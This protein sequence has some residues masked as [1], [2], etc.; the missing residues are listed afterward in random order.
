MW[1]CPDGYPGTPHGQLTLRVDAAPL[2]RCLQPGGQ[3]AVEKVAGDKGREAVRMSVE[4]ADTAGLDDR[5][6]RDGICV[7]G[8]YTAG[9]ATEVGNSFEPCNGAGGSG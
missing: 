7:G 2:A 8:G 3:E 9:G 4:V 1:Q 6:L 5:R